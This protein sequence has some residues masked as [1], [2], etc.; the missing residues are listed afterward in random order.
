MEKN[1]IKWACIQPLTGG[2]YLGAAEAIGHDAEW[3]LSYDGLDYVKYEKDGSE[4]KDA[5]NE[6]NLLQYLKKHNRNVPYYKICNR[7][8]FETNTLTTNIEIRR[9]E[10]PEMPN[11]SDI[12]LIVS[13]PVCSGLSMV[14]KASS[15]T[16]NSRN[17]NMEW[18]AYYVLNV[19]RPKV[20]CFENA[21]TLISGRGDY[22]RTALENMAMSCGY[23]VLYYKTDT[24]YHNSCQRRPRTF[25]IFFKWQNG[26]PE[27]PP[28]FEYEH[29]TV[30]IPEFFSKISKDAPQQIPV[31]SSPHNYMAIDYL[32]K[33]YGDD[34]TDKLVNLN[35]VTHIYMEGKINDFIQFIKDGNYN[36]DDK[37]K[38]IKYL[39]HM[40]EKKNKGLNYFSQDAC[41]FKNLFP[42]VQFRSIPNMLHY[43]G[44]RFCTI[45]EYLSLMGMPEDFILYGGEKC[46]A[47]IGQ[48]VPVNTA[49]FIVSQILN[50]VTNIDYISTG[51]IDEN[52]K[53]AN[54]IMQDNTK[55]NLTIK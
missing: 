52:N 13:V 51:F 18:L 26:H 44:K 31:K 47:K 19:I 24:V 35:I 37:K 38:S 46:V 3:I 28:K 5:G 41:L 48:N 49:K 40:I 10:L 9:D 8:M 32:N 36:E 22:I 33:E 7:N 25:V 27:L 1:N 15:A 2:M 34:W 17:C 20:Y 39:Q 55:E 11:Y 14:T 53:T 50:Y 43:S 42:S 23:S 30:T 16:K 54:V 45:R 12:D 6:Y 4:I 29:K 21:P